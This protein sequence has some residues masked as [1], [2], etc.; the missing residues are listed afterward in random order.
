MQKYLIYLI[1]DGGVIY[2]TSCGVFIAATSHMIHQ[3][4]VPAVNI[5]LL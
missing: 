3:Q 1:F 4:V 2:I 5:I